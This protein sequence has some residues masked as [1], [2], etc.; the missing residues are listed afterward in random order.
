MIENKCYTPLNIV[1]ESSWQ[2]LNSLFLP[3]PFNPLLP[4]S[5]PRLHSLL[6]IK[7][8]GW[9]EAGTFYSPLYHS[10]TSV[11]KIL[12][13]WKLNRGVLNLKHQ[14]W[15]ASSTTIH[16]TFQSRQ[17]KL[18][19][20]STNMIQNVSVQS[21]SYQ[22]LNYQNLMLSIFPCLDIFSGVHLLLKDFSL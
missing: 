22:N 21:L 16:I 11:I 1:C 8:Y 15:K 18:M 14:M 7:P 19:S 3:P 6:L 2:R 5:P 4:P 17:K 9:F 13:P 12:E 10:V 20:Y